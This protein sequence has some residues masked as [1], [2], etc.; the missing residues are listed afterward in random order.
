MPLNNLT[1]K[2]LDIVTGEEIIRPYTADEIAIVETERAEI[3]T[4]ND[5]KQQEEAAKTAARQVVLDKLGLT[6]EEAATLLA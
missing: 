6:A 4:A 1:E 5:A 3:L 2:I